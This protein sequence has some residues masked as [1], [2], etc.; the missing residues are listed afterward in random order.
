MQYFLSEKKYFQRPEIKERI[1]QRERNYRKTN[2]VDTIADRLRRSFNHAMNKYS[3][4]GKIIS[5]KKYGL[6]W[7]EIIEHLKPFPKNIQDFEIDHIIP[8]HNF[9]LTDPNQVKLAFS[10]K[11]LQWLPMIENRRKSGKIIH[12]VDAEYLKV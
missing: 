7:E 1:R 10:P 5:S 9:N 4:T 3:N 8:L 11:N 6:N 12:G 2:K